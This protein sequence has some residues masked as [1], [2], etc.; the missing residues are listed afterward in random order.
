M[1]DNTL[2]TAGFL[3]LIDVSILAAAREIGFADA[4]GIELVLIRESSWANVRDRMAIGHF[5]V[6]HMLAPMP[7]A[8]NLGLTPFDTD[9]IA[10]MA[11][12][13]GGN[14]ITVSSA[15]AATLSP[16]PSGALAAGAALKT[17]IDGL[18]ESGDPKLKFGVVH[19]HSAHNFE[20]RYWLAASGIDPDNAVEIVI[21]PPSLMAD[22]LERGSIDGYCVG[23]PWNTLAQS[24]GSGQILATKND[25]W[26]SSPE[27]VLGVDARWARK[28]APALAALIRALHDA[29]LWCGEQGNLARLAEILSR[30]DY[31]GLDPEILH[32]SLTGPAGYE[33]HARAATFPW[34]S[35]AT[36]FYTQMV[37]WGQ[38]AH[39]PSHVDVARRTYRPDIYREAL[40]NAG[41]AIPAA[42]SKVE[43]ALGAPTI[44]GAGRSMLQL[45]PDGFFDGEV[46]DPDHVD[47]YIARQRTRDGHD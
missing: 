6:A 13:L 20:L 22:A 29:S 28:N 2:I 26:A 34:Q 41:A 42:S 11:L 3:P 14:A 24:R 47:A 39:Q 44:V 35:H 9:I 37:R 4:E 15:L 23:E 25:I 10:P 45:G 38:V 46:F 16:V 19:P 8:S 30:P 33:P 12:G 27:K 17:H 31:L 36:W 7:I 1:A 32:A 18:A 21:L 43:G 40:K 5:D